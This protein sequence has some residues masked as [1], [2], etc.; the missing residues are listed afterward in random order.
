MVRLG[1]GV[2]STG[3]GPLATLASKPIV[4]GSAALVER[5]FGPD[6]PRKYKGDSRS[7]WGLPW[8]TKSTSSG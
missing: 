5:F 6:Y 2:P 3:L 7:D 8:Q 4:A 1:V